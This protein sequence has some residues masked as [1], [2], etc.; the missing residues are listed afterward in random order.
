MTRAVDIRTRLYAKEPN[1]LCPTIDRIHELLDDLVHSSMIGKP[2]MENVTS[3]RSL[4][5]QLRE[6]ARGFRDWNLTICHEV[7]KLCAE[8]LDE[9]PPDT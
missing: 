3:I 7:E 6:E 5:E 8:A 9:S 4:L 1:Y 2:R